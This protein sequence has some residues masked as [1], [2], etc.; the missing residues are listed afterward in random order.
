[1]RHREKHAELMTTHMALP[2]ADAADQ[3]ASLGDDRGRTDA[4]FGAKCL[5]LPIGEMPISSEMKA[6]S[7]C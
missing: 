7:K 5:V 1:M 3:I 2:E 6:R 4:W